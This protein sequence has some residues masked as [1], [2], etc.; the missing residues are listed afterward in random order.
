MKDAKE[1]KNNARTFT[2]ILAGILFK[3]VMKKCAETE[4]CVF[5]P[6]QR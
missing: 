5:L 1:K 4:I 6:A 2:F 3:F